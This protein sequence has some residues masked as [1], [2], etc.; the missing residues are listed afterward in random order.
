[1]KNLK[2]FNLQAALSGKAV[3]L[4]NGE[5]A[6]VRHHETELNAEEHRKLVGYT[7]IGVIL[8]WRED[9]RFIGRHIEQD[10]DIVGMCPETKLINGFEVPLPVQEALAHDTEYYV[11]L[12]TEDNFCGIHRW[13]ND[14]FD[15]R[16]LQRG[17]VF[18]N[19]ED[20]VAN[21]KALLGIVPNSEEKKC[22][23]Q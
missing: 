2:P 13:F 6:F 23:R 12:L 4:R 14:V 3:M 7:S 11:P 5:K 18:L 8:S 22:V 19:K 9:G 20:A 21:A 1:M 17:L 16:A 15:E 10:M